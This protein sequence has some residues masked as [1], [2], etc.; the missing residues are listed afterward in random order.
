MKYSLFVFTIVLSGLSLLVIPNSYGLTPPHQN[1]DYNQQK[2]WQQDYLWHL[3]KN[4]SVGD[5]YT[6]RICDPKTI[7]TSASNYHYFTQG[8]NDHNSSTC[9]TIKLDFVNLLTSDEN[10]INERNVWVVQSAVD[11]KNDL[12]YSVFYIDTLTFE[13]SS[14]DTIHHLDT[15]KYAD[16]LQKTLFSLFKYTASEPQLLQIGE[17]WGEVT[18]ALQ[19]KGEIHS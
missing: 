19:P 1:A 6:Y 10:Q 9:Y 18:E 14:S 3:G 15:K 5:S 13:I 8:N 16:S 2:L 12:R 11:E 4:L 7:Q 17:S